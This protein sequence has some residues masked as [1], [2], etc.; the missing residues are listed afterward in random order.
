[1]PVCI[2][3]GGWRTVLTLVLC[4]RIFLISGYCTIVECAVIEDANLNYYVLS[5]L[6]VVLCTKCLDVLNMTD[7]FYSIL[8]QS[9]LITDIFIAL[10]VIRCFAFNV[11]DF[12]LNFFAV[13]C[14]NLDLWQVLHSSYCHHFFPVL[15]MCMYENKDTCFQYMFSVEF[16]C[17]YIYVTQHE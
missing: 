7:F 17:E 15:E 3:L 4:C 2:T 13:I 1:M 6:L 8:F 9:R 5:N 16:M 11:L 10:I 12:W 14:F